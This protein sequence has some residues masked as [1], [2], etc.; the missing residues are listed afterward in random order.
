MRRWLAIKTALVS[1]LTRNQME[2]EKILLEA[3]TIVMFFSEYAVYFLWTFS[4]FGGT[5]CSSHSQ[6]ERVLNLTLA[7]FLFPIS[8]A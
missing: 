3:D 2:N 1:I 6:L 8:S 4:H 7:L 5:T